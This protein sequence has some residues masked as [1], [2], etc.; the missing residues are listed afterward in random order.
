MGGAGRTAA[1]WSSG[2]NYK[3]ESHVIYNMHLV[4]I[5]GLVMLSIHIDHLVYE[6]HI[7]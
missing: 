2:H 3:L 1:A 4:F 7:H 5:L 6:V